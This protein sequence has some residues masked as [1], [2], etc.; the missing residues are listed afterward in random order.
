MVKL[1]RRDGFPDRSDGVRPFNHQIP[2]EPNDCRK[3]FLDRAPPRARPPLRHAC[4]QAV[5][6]RKLSSLK[7]RGLNPSIIKSERISIPL[8]RLTG[9]HIMSEKAEEAGTSDIEW[10]ALYVVGLILI[11]AAVFVVV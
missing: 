2:H 5:V 10:V 8:R 6:S 9:G 1:E 3:V 11:I 7:V 4:G